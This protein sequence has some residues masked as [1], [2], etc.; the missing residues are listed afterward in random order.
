MADDIEKSAS[1]P[2]SGIE[3][4]TELP[5][6][7]SPPLSPVGDVSA[8]PAPSAPESAE[9]IT[10]KPTPWRLRMKAR[11]RHQAVLAASVATAAA[12]GA[13][14]GALAMSRLNTPPIDTTA[15]RER[16]ALEQSIGKL[17]KEIAALKANVD[18]DATSAR[19]QI[20]KITERLNHEPEPQTTGSISTPAAVPTPAPR[21][22]LR[23]S[24]VRDW[25]IYD[26]RGGFVSV[27]QGHGDIY[28]VVLGAPLP[29]LGPV[30]QIKRENGRWIVVTPKGTIVSMRDR[31]YFEP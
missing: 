28:Q 21:P 8:A 23:S 1:A 5:K 16:Q 7:E 10:P 31:R 24:I 19:T 29:G 26:A 6:V 4:D 11:H 20:A 14:I 3:A 22:N 30:E 15:R 27:Q 9:K 12:I 13:V 17:N 18:T 2:K 25:S